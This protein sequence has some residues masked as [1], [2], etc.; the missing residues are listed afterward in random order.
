MDASLNWGAHCAINIHAG[1]IADM[2][3]WEMDVNGRLMPV[4]GHQLANGAWNGPIT[5]LR[6]NYSAA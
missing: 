2:D 5:H 1:A 4:S 6:Y 3:D